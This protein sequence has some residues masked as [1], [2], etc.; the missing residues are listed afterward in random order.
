V[1][2]LLIPIVSLLV[3]LLVCGAFA[4]PGGPVLTNV[5]VRAE[6]PFVGV[7]GDITNVCAPTIVYV[8]LSCV[9][10]ESVHPFEARADGPWMSNWTSV[11][12]GRV[13]VVS[14]T[15]S[16][17][18]GSCSAGPFEVQATVVL[19]LKQVGTVVSIR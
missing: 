13:Y 14:V 3:I 9:G 18:F 10:D 6:G 19:P 7:T 2:L 17:V 12:P 1:N 4:A 5:V 11:V 15:A 8:R 16:N